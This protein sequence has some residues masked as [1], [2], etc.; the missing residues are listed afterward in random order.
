[1]LKKK[2]A[3]KGYVVEEFIC[4][5]ARSLDTV[6]N[7]SFDTAL[8]MGPMYHILDKS[9]RMKTL[10]NLKRIMKKNG[11]AIIAYLNSWGVL[12]AGIT[13]FPDSYKNIKTIRALLNEYIHIAKPGGDFPDAY[14]T[15]PEKALKE[16]ESAGFNILSYAG[17]ESFAAGMKYSIERLYKEK[18]KIY[19]NILKVVAE[20]CELPQFRDITEHL[21]IVVGKP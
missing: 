4:E 1:M 17:V 19:R 3:Q 11:T 2:I 15:V 7:R 8:L 10:K 13:E 14:F 9:D 21:H 18:R 12:R 6:K 20:T 16:V 5:D